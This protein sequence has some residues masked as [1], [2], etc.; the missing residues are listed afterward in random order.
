MID[1]EGMIIKVSLHKFVFSKKNNK[2]SKLF[3]LN[4]KGNFFQLYFT[5]INAS[6]SHLNYILHL[7][8]HHVPPFHSQEKYFVLVITFCWAFEPFACTTHVS[9]TFLYIKHHI[10]LLHVFFCSCVLRRSS[11]VFLNFHPE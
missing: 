5:F 10:N 7:F 6:I 1:L 11:M 8:G 4:K 2:N 3:S 9:F